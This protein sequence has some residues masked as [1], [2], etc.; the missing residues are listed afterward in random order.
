[1]SEKNFGTWRQRLWPVHT[2]ELKKLLPLLCIKFLI[3]FNYGILNTLKDTFIVTGKN[4]GAEVIPVLKGWVVLPIAILVSLLYAKLSNHLKRATIFNGIIIFYILFLLFYSFFLYPN[5]DALSPHQSSEWLLGKI[6]IKYSHWIAVYRNWIPSIFFVL[7]ELWASLAIFMLFWGLCNQIN[8]IQEAKRYYTLFITAGN[9]GAVLTGPLVGYY[10]LKYA[11]T[12]FSYTLQS[13][14]LYV[15]AFNLI[16]LG[17]HWWMQKYVLVDKKFYD[18]LST[19]HQKEVKTKLSLLQGI[20]YVASSRY[21]RYIAVMVISYGLTISLVEL[22]WKA[23]LKMAY[24]NPAEY[25]AFYGKVISMVGVVAMFASF[26]LGGGIIR[27]FGWHFS[28][29]ITPYIVGMTGLI[30]LTLVSV[31]GLLT[32]LITTFGIVPLFCIVIFG[33]FQNVCSKALKYTFFD[34]TKEMTYIPLDQESKVKGKAAIDMVGSRFGKSGSA[35]IQLALIQ[36]SGTGSILSITSLLIPFV[37]ATVF[38]WIYSVKNLNKLFQKK[39]S[40]ENPENEL[41]KSF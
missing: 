22:S 11:H 20:K 29:Q 28:A 9:L 25:Q 14:T 6:G 40:H 15:V 34:P 38:F 30:F 41:E 17:L 2:F 35:W 27:F 23:S 1:M 36:F 24:P 32:P 39:L 7:A 31:Q 21:L 10:A 3:S 26:F 19:K 18:S 33:A 8:V 37:T 13:L 16:I 4:S 12:H 5:S